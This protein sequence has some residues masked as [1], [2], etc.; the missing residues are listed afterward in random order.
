QG[1]FQ[2]SVELRTESDRARTSR[3]ED[4]LLPQLFLLFLQGFVQLKQ[5]PFAQFFVCRPVGF[6]EGTA[7]GVDCAMHV[8]LR[9]V[10]NLPYYLFS[11]RVDIAEGAGL[12][13][14]ELAVDHRLLF[15]TD[16]RLHRY[17]SPNRPTRC[18]LIPSESSCR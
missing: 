10:G 14:D 9:R 4:Q 7:C 6:V 16:V 1:V 18:E 2:R 15:E 3:F 5:A 11:R 12:A 13:V 8:C 17:S